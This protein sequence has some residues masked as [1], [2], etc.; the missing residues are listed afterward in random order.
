MT[1]SVEK[2]DFIS[3]L[4]QDVERSRAF[5]TGLLGLPVSASGDF[6]FEVDEFISNPTTT[7]VKI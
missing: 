7:V 4:T 3:V 5:Y 1:V 6:W 2:V